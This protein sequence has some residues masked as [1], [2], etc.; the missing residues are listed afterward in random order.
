MAKIIER[1]SAI[2]SLTHRVSKFLSRITRG[3]LAGPVVAAAVILDPALP[4][5]EGLD[6]SKKLTPKQRERI[7]DEILQTAVA[8][9][10][11]QVEPEEIDRINILQAS[12]LA[13]TEALKQ[14]APQADYL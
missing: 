9:S 5:P 14:L 2:H 13:M 4:F 1:N 12:R 8:F 11:G 3:A 7:A 6:D 10:V